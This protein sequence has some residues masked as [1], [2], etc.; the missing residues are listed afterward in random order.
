MSRVLILCAALAL[1]A[2][3]TV[4]DYV[5]PPPVIDACPPSATAA[6]EPR[7]PQ[8]P[9]TEAEQGALDLSG[10]QT[11]GVDRF[12]DHSLSEAQQ[13][14]RAVRLESRIE[15]TRTW[16]VSRQPRPG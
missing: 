1:G 11:L 3:Q 12:A 4:P 2:C 13:D 14:A 15:Q 16:C 6:L 7:P 9:I 8:V 10:I 5:P